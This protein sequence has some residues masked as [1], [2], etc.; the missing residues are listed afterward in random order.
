MLIIAFSPDKVW[1][2]TCPNQVWCFQNALI[3]QLIQFPLS[4]QVLRFENILS[5]ILHFGVLPLANG[6]GFLGNNVTLTL[7]KC[8]G[9]SETFHPEA[10][11][12]NVLL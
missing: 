9:L 2:S 12:S 10:C 3:W 7:A 5:S 1:E 11:T 4:F 6:K 8:W